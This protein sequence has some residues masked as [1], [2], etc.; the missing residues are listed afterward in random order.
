MRKKSIQGVQKFSFFCMD[1][2]MKSKLLHRPLWFLVWMLKEPSLNGT[3]NKSEFMHNEFV[4]VHSTGQSM[5]RGWR[6]YFV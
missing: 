6:L 3:L 2:T 1:K 5:K 4:L